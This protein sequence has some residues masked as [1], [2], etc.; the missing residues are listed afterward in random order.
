MTFP[1]QGQQLTYRLHSEEDIPGLLRLW[2]ENTGWGAMAPEQWRQW[3]VDT[4]YGPC[5]IP[6][7]VDGTGAVRG[8]IVLT[9]ARLAVADREV[10]ALRLSAPILQKELRGLKREH[11]ALSLYERA[12]EAARGQQYEFIYAYPDQLVAPFFRRYTTAGL[13]DSN[14][15]VM[16]VEPGQ[17]NLDAGICV[18]PESGF[19]DEYE[20]L[21][22]ES[23]CLWPISVG[24]VRS[25]EWLKFRNGGRLTLGVR[26]T[27]GDLMGYSALD[28]RNGLLAD[29]LARRPEDLARVVSATIQWLGSQADT[30][31]R[32]KA[33]AS[34]RMTTALVNAGFTP[35]SYKFLFAYCTLGPDLRIDPS[36]MSNWHLMPGD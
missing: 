18:S 11:P 4:P 14:C 17:T 33:M 9:P 19:G 8:Q 26:S 29:C 16:Q 6:V 23:R 28:R 20:R 1:A 31:T 12:L 21:W 13:I 24:I 27:A 36:D 7:A 34:P 32:I 35:E 30:P 22:E 2:E 5:L 3:Y 10:K 15:L 25:R